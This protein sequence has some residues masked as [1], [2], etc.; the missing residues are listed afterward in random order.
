M[1]KYLIALYVGLAGVVGVTF[2]TP[3]LDEA[4]AGTEPSPFQP[5]INQLLAVSNILNSADFRVGKSI[6]HPPDPC[7][8]PDPCNSPDLNGAINR[9]EAISKQVSSVDDM[10]DSMIS[11]V[12]GFE[13]TPFRDDLFPALKTVRDAAV[14]I[15]SQVNNYEP[16]DNTPLEYIDAL[17][18]VGK[19][20]FDV[21]ETTQGGICAVTDWDELCVERGCTWL[22]DENECIPWQPGY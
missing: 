18:N 12:M 22:P 13:P 16:G 21:S 11:E 1:K 7:V 2:L 9:L 4:K 10:V 19:K 6:A 15:E 3:A 20:A 8:P 14:G 5:E 17:E